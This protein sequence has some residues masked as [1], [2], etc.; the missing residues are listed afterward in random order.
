MKE[1]LKKYRA[2]LSTESFLNALSL[3]GFLGFCTLFFTSFVFWFINQRIW[4]SGVIALVVTVTSTAIL[5]RKFF[6]LSDRAL[7]MRVD[8]LGLEERILTMIQ[9]EGD[10]SL[11]ARKQRE[12]TLRVLETVNEGMIPLRVSKKTLT[13]LAIAAVCGLSMTCVCILGNR[14]IIK[15]G[16]SLIDDIITPAPIE[17]EVIY[18]VDG[19]G[20]IDGDAFQVVQ[21]GNNASGVTAVAEDG[22]VFESWSDGVTDPNRQDLNITGNLEIIATF[23]ELEE[24]ES[25]EGD[26]DGDATEELPS[27]EDNDDD[28]NNV[29]PGSGGTTGSGG[30]G[31]YTDNNQIIDGETYYG[32]STFDNAY[33]DM[34]EALLKNDDIS[35]ELKEFIENYFKIIE[36]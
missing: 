33:E 9:L 29:P 1:Y 27:D 7:A 35:D 24:G 22:W 19:E 3:G 14:G 20:M 16:S 10:D 2:K 18:D 25:E 34:L 13:A 6:L 5:Y 8:E 31:V 12:D 11:I 26:G 17:Y 15:D 23:T 28:N 21:E 32:G 4:L 30:S 36:K